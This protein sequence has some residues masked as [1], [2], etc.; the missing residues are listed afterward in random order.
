MYRV[1]NRIHRTFVRHAFVAAL[2]VLGG[3][4][5]ANAQASRPTSSTPSIIG[6]QV[7][8]GHRITGGVST[9]YPQTRGQFIFG[10]S[11]NFDVGVF[12][13]LTYGTNRI[14]GITQRVGLWLD[15]PL[16]WNLATLPKAA[17]A[18]RFVPYFRVGQYDP[19]FGVG[20]T[21]G[22][23]VSMPLPKIFSIVFGVETRGGFGSSGDGDFRDNY[24]DGATY[25][26]LGL[27][28]LFRNQFFFFLEHDFGGA[29]ISNDGY[30]GGRG[31]YNF[32]IGFGAY[33]R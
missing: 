28:A 17:I 31:L 27:E 26:L 1:S 15:V 7:I 13:G 21:L 33:L 32:H 29:Y 2:V 3:T 10:I 16:R 5:V 25:G 20:G 8:G 11:N 19:S 30:G 24:F 14:A 12:P 22:V 23:R 6:G 18:L 4:T 9:G